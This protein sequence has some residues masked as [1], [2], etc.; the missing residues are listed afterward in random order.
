MP[1]FTNHRKGK[2]WKATRYKNHHSYIVSTFRS[3]W[4]LWQELQNNEVVSW[5]G[6]EDSANFPCLAWGHS[7]TAKCQR[8]ERPSKWWIKHVNS[9]SHIEI[10]FS[11][12]CVKH[13][14]EVNLWLP[15]PRCWILWSVLHDPLVLKRPMSV[16]CIRHILETCQ[17]ESGSQRRLVQRSWMRF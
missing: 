15:P 9:R 5:K 6:I 11:F 3:Q 8:Q 4:P 7:F 17:W 12:N 13:C 10:L 14:P 16:D 1:P 2:L